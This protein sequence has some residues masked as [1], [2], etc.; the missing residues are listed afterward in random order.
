M[1]AFKIQHKESKKFLT[2]TAYRYVHWF[3]E[4][5][6]IGKALSNNGKVFS[7]Y[8]GVNNAFKKLGKKMNLFEIKEFN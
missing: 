1:G 7:T 8:S 6:G 4:H 5:Y 2:T 3:I